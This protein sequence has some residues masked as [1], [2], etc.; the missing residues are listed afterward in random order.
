M[1]E[2]NFNS[3]RHKNYRKNWN[4]YKNNPEFN[5]P[6][7]KYI[8][9]ALGKEICHLYRDLSFKDNINAHIKEDTV[10]NDAVDRIIYSNEF[11]SLLPEM[12]VTVAAKGGAL[13]KNYLN[14]GVSEISYI[15][16]EN[17]FPEFDPFNQRKLI[18]ETIAFPVSNGNDNL[19]Y[20][21]IYEK[22][23]DGYYWCVT[24]MNVFN[25]NEIG[26]EL[27][28]DEV[29]TFLTESPLTYIPFARHNGDF[30]GYSIFYGLEPLLEELNWRASQISNILD[31]FSNPNVIGS[32]SLLDD[33]R[34]FTL[35]EGGVYIP[36]EDGEQK[37]EYLVWNANLQANFDYIEQILFKVL[38]YIS[39]LNPSLF[40]MDKASQ[41]SARAVKL[42]SFRTQCVIE[43]SLI[44]WKQAVKKCLF[45]AQQL[46]NISGAYNYTP[47]IPNVEIYVS[48]PRDEFEQS[49]EEQLKVASKVTSRKSAIARLNPHYTSAQVEEEFLNIMD[50]TNEAN[51][52]TFMD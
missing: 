10:A 22:R 4:I 37:P 51:V 9:L 19:L 41:A 34:T 14:N 1:T 42:K 28:S 21:E 36:V 2:I 50:E 16:P 52:Q 7:D 5:K 38:H 17:Y 47:H 8:P 12:A 35:S 49:Q 3:N 30:F 25:E 13:L 29:N 11:D 33:D 43:N 48:M 26:D 31:K 27:E 15:Q 20:R 40:G 24:K 18:R 45:L 44:Y 46:E 39:P 23:D 6:D 32:Q